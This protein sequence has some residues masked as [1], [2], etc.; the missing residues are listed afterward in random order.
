MRYFFTELNVYSA[1]Y[2][3]AIKSKNNYSK[4][5]KNWNIRVFGFDIVKTTQYLLFLFSNMSIEKKKKKIESR[6]LIYF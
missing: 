3:C 5:S 4:S 6:K 1:T 2:F